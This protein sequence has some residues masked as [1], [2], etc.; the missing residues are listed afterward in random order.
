MRFYLP[1]YSD[2]GTKEYTYRVLESIVKDS[3]HELVPKVRSDR[4]D[5]V[6]V[7]LCDV[8]DISDLKRTREEFPNTYIIAGGHF[9]VYWKL[10]G[11]FADL[12]N[13]GQGFELFECSTFEEMEALN[14]TYTGCE[15]QIVPSTKID[16]NVVPVGR[17]SKKVYYYWAATGCR[18][19]CGF[20]LTSW[21]HKHQLN[22]EFRIKKAEAAIPDNTFLRLVSNEY[23]EPISNSTVRDVMLTDFLDMTKVGSSYNLL[24]M[25]VEFATEGLRDKY[26]KG[27]TDEQFYAAIEKSAELGIEIQMFMITGLN[28][29]QEWLDFLTGVPEN[30]DTYPRVTFKFTNLDFHQYTP[31]YRL[32]YDV[33][34]NKYFQRSDINEWH[35]RIA[36]RNQRIRTYGPAHPAI[37]F[38]RSAMQAVTDR[39]QFEILW[40]NRELRDAEAMLGIWRDTTMDNFYADQLKLEPIDY[41]VFE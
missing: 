35:D 6:L 13:V 41:G 33:D 27:F 20:C 40:N 34:I 21:T 23:S 25:G 14:C 24:R 29:E 37:A 11:L 28:T 2:S 17:S 19:K 38:W 32:R 10:V 31:F 7:S 1:D 30:R 36:Y 39:N 22:N 9:G 12:V 16:W 15:D 18:H 3:E 8:N 4:A 5:A 26:A